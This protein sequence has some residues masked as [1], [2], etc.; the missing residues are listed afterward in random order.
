M[1][2][3]GGEG[4]GRCGA[5]GSINFGGCNWAPRQEE[6]CFRF[7]AG[8]NGFISRVVREEGVLLDIEGKKH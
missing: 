4:M 8:E 6:L 2:F 5:L 3:F 7:E 1:Q